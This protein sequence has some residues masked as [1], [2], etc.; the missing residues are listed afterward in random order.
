M[1][2]DPRRVIPILVQSG[3]ATTEALYQEAERDARLALSLAMGQGVTGHE[4]Q[5]W[6]DY[7]VT[8]IRRAGVPEA[9]VD[10]ASET[11]RRQHHEDHLWTWI[12]EGAAEALVRIR[13]MGYRLGIVS[14][15][16]GRVEALLQR[17]GLAELVEFVIDSH[18]VG[19]S[20][21]DPRIFRMGA[22]RLGL[23]PEECLYVGDLYAIDVIGARGA[24]LQPLLLDP[25]D[26]LGHWEDVDRIASVAEL[27]AWLT[28]RMG[29]GPE[30]RDDGGTGPE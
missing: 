14:N 4:D 16:D 2:V 24:G 9:Q 30:G 27:P 23:P 19:V 18:A 28:T 21:P 29:G 3:A 12:Q 10:L 17:L 20:K 15:A 11:L 26:R 7:F 8:V 5:F 22:D 13:E 6:R 25:F 1:F